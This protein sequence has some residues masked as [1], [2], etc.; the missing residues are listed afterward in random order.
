LLGVMKMVV[1]KM[2]HATR[3]KASYK[4]RAPIHLNGHIRLPLF[5]LKRNL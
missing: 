4:S 5:Q 1:G 3:K 2:K